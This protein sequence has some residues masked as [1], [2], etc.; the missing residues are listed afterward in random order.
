MGDRG[1]ETE[2]ISSALSQNALTLCP[3]YPKQTLV[4]DQPPGCK[5]KVLGLVNQAIGEEGFQIHCGSMEGGRLQL[6]SP[7]PSP[8]EKFKTRTFL[9][10]PVSMY[11]R[12]CLLPQDPG[13]SWGIMCPEGAA[14][15]KD[16][17]AK[18]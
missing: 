1:Q 9:P 8:T 5:I 16:R 3:P 10:E 7:L 14:L 6:L 18:V 4:A 11:V 2:W 13:L 17:L 12:Q 15:D